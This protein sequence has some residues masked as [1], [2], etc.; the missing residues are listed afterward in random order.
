M[1]DGVI[2]IGSES[3]NTRLMRRVW[4]TR[5]TKTKALIVNVLWLGNDTPDAIIKDNVMAGAFQRAYQDKTGVML[6]LPS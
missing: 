1:I 4:F 3:W 6:T 5:D 2:G